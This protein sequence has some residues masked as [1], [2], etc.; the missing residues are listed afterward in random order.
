MPYDPYRKIM[1]P[2]FQADQ[3]LPQWQPM[4][5]SDQGEQF[6]QATGSFVDLLK[7]RMAGGGAASGS[8][9]GAMPSMEGMAGGGEGG[10]MQS[11]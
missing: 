3:N 7:K 9:G 11:L 5:E 1:T 4:G 10:G 6:G 8:K 2:D